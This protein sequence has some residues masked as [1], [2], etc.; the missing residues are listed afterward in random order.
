MD[1]VT[2]ELILRSDLSNLI[3]NGNSAGRVASLIVQENSSRALDSANRVLLPSSSGSVVNWE[4]I[5]RKPHRNA[6]ELTWVNILR[7]HLISTNDVLSLQSGTPDAFW[8]SRE[9]RI[10][11][12]FSRFLDLLC[13]WDFEDTPSLNDLVIEDDDDE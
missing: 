11:K 12:H 10:K 6:D 13:E 7:S 1:F 9:N 3:G 5:L 8:E 2:G 4:E